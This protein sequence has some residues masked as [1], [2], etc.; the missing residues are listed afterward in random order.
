MRQSILD[1]AMDDTHKLEATLGGTDR[2]KLDEYLTSV[3]SI[4]KDVERTRAMKDKA[5]GRAAHR[6]FLGPP[7]QDDYGPD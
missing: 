1:R 3:R 5:D 7:S 6:R 2:R 4:E